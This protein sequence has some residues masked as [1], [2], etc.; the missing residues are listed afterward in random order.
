MLAE[1]VSDLADPDVAFDGTNYFVVWRDRRG[2]NDDVYGTRV[3]VGGDVL[4][5]DGIAISRVVL[6]QFEPAVAFDGAN[7][8]VVWTD[9]RSIS[10]DIYCARV[11]PGGTVLDSAGIAISCASGL[12][13]SPDVAFD[14]N[15]FLVVWQDDRSDS[16][17][18]IYGARV[19]P[20]GAVLDPGGLLISDAP[21]NQYEPA[22]ACNGAGFLVVWADPRNG[23]LDIYGARVTSL[24][25]VLDT[26]G[27]PV[28]LATLG[29]NRPS[30]AFDGTDVLVA[31]EDQRSGDWF[32]R[33]ARVTAAGEVLDPAGF[34]I[35]PRHPAGHA[36]VA[37]GDTIFLVTWECN[38]GGD[39]GLD[40]E[41]ARVT[42]AAEVLDPGGI[43]LTTAANDQYSPSAAFNGASYLAV[44]QDERS[45]CSGYHDIYARRLSPQ[46][47]RLDSARFVAARADY[48][49]LNPAVVS[50]GSGWLAV[51]ENMYDIFGARVAA[52]GTVL[53]PNGFV[54]V[55]GYLVENP[56]VSSDGTNYL[57]L[58]EDARLGYFSRVCG[59]RVTPDGVVL[60]TNGFPVFARSWNCSY[61]ALAFDG[62]NYLA[63]WQDGRNEPYDDIYGARVTPDGVVL[64]PDGIAVAAAPNE[65]YFPALAWGGAS[66][67]V[68]WQDRRS[69]GDMVYAARVASDG[70]VRDPDGISVTRAGSVW[71]IPAVAFDGTDY[72][73]AW[74]DRRGLD[75]D[76]YCARLS[77]DGAI[78]D[79]GPVVVRQGDQAN[80]GL[81][82]G[83]GDQVLLTYDGMA[84]MVSGKVYYCSRVWGTFGPFPGVQESRESRSI[85]PVTQAT[86]VRGVL[87]V[88]ASSF[89]LRP[90]LFDMTG[91]KVMEL[92][93]G[94]NDVR[95][96][97][98][99][100]Y[101]IREAQAQAQAQT[102]AQAVRKVVI[103]R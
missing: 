26:A 41:G 95:G 19:T 84:G 32:V 93:P 43:P 74:P 76:I 46:G 17:C 53:D 7:Y 54:I 52:D 63:V 75:D 47:T 16:S 37:F 2:N 23:D 70:T 50:N 24:G 28:A 61:P 103:T 39:Y 78:L 22:V 62:T 99:G 68:A 14:G 100:V 34:A 64:D 13:M 81:A 89:S 92:V 56:A 94:P 45:R 82:R 42:S 77:P 6:Q 87:F 36:A 86:I 55:S 21:G 91:R 80:V 44:W 49:Q 96:L 98:P 72:V 71:P 85:Y 15:C 59:A 38:I 3:T 66:Y 18:D 30:V 69:F 73:V 25:A 33:G 57:V 51:W 5:P 29:Q 9:E 65:Q 35:T 4:D 40:V 20:D 79:S 67:L 58:W 10:Y 83:P 1:S 88:P 12:Q 48:D 102:Q 60:D 90:S 31:W 11:T 97:A 8:L 27:I 101:F